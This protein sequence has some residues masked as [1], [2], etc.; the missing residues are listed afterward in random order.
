MVALARYV[1]CH[2][3]SHVV[4]GRNPA[5]PGMYKNLANNGINSILINKYQLNLK[6]RGYMC[7]FFWEEGVSIFVI[8]EVFRFLW[9]FM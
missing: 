8:F 5:L 2:A 7:I 3:S 1:C 4:D 6:R 9:V